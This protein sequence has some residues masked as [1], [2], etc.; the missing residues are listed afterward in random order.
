MGRSIINER[1][2]RGLDA[3]VVRSEA[4]L[5]RES[6]SRAGPEDTIFYRETNHGR[7]CTA[8]RKEEVALHCQILRLAGPIICP[9]NGASVTVRVRSVREIPRR[10]PRK[11]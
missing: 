5:T 11:H 4:R 1:A 8:T 9:Y 6:A 7:L 3:L 2:G 10:S